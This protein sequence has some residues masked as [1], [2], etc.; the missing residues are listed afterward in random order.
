MALTEKQAELLTGP[1]AQAIDE[2]SPAWLLWCELH[3]QAPGSCNRV[4]ST[5]YRL[6][7]QSRELA[8]SAC[9]AIPE[10]MYRSTMYPH[11]T[12]R[13]TDYVTWHDFVQGVIERRIIAKRKAVAA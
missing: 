13:P 9:K 3:D 8:E 7:I 4:V 1:R 5:E 6:F 10:A 11:E 2:W 12:P